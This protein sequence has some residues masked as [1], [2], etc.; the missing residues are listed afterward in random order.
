MHE[1]I[2]GILKKL[3]KIYYLSDLRN[4]IARFSGHMIAVM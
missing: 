3:Q 2:K 1:I 4:G